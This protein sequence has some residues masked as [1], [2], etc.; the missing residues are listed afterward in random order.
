MVSLEVGVKSKKV[1]WQSHWCQL[2]EEARTMKQKKEEREK[3]VVKVG[4]YID[5]HV[6]VER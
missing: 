2:K 1:K 3:C 5:F 4:V 6:S